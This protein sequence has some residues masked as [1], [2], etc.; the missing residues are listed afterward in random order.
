ML[1]SDWVGGPKAGTGKEKREEGGAASP[2]TL[3]SGSCQPLARTTHPPG[4]WVPPSGLRCSGPAFC[5]GA[6]TPLAPRCPPGSRWVTGRAGFP[7]MAVSWALMG[8]GRLPPLWPGLL[9]EARAA[10]CRLRECGSFRHPQLVKL[11]SGMIEAGK[12]YVTTNR[13]FVSGVRDLSQQ[14]QGDTVISVRGQ[15]ISDL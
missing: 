5:S 4:P 11:C 14:C 13:L 1:L 3:T 15:L 12:A 10:T 2:S 7:G 8:P 9:E 6:K